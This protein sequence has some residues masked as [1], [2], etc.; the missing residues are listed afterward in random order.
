MH[1]VYIH[2]LFNI[3]SCRNSF[4]DSARHGSNALKAAGLVVH[5]EEFAE[6]NVLVLGWEICKPAEFRPARK[7]IWRVRVGIRELLRRGW[8]SGKMLERLVGQLC[9]IALGKREIYSVLGSVFAFISKNYSCCSRIWPSVRRE[10]ML[11][12]ALSPLLV[13]NL[14]APW[15]DQIYSVDASFWGLGVCTTQ[16]PLEEVKTTFRHAERWRFQSEHHVKA[17]RVFDYG[18]DCH[19]MPSVP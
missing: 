3:G 10:L 13:T 14:A 16:V 5:E 4:A 12:D 18:H 6:D 15:S 17:R 2:N 7:R 1:A 9:F 8:A 19:D 11:F